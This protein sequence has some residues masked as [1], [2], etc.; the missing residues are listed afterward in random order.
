[1]AN[2]AQ[3]FKINYDTNLKHEVLDSLMLL[4]P[5]LEI[6]SFS[7]LSELHVSTKKINFLCLKDLN[8]LRKLKKTKAAIFIFCENFNRE[9]IISLS[10][11]FNI[12]GIYE[13]KDLLE[14]IHEIKT[15]NFKREYKYGL[16]SIAESNK[17]AQRITKL[18]SL[19]ELLIEIKK[20]FQF[21]KKMNPPMLAIKKSFQQ[22]DLMFSQGDKIITHNIFGSLDDGSRMRKNSTSDREILA[23]ALSRP[24]AK[25][26]A[27]P[28]KVR[29]H[30]ITVFLEHDLSDNELDPQIDV[31][32][33]KLQIIEPIL[34]V[35]LLERMSNEAS[36]IWEKTFES[37]NDPVAIIDENFNLLRGNKR[38]KRHM[39]VEKCYSAFFDTKEVCQYCPIMSK[40][41]ELRGNA[42]NHLITKNGE[43]YEVH[44]SP[45]FLYDKKSV[46]GYANHY[47]NLTE[48]LN[49]KSRII[50]SEKMAAIGHLA[51]NI[52]H[53][54]NNPLTGIRS[55]AQLLIS[56]IHKEC[57][58]KSDLQEVE[59]AAARCQKIILNLLEYTKGQNTGARQMNLNE[60]VGKT[61]PLLKMALRPFR[62]NI[63]YSDEPIE[64][65]INEQLLQQVIFN[66]ILNSTQAMGQK[67]S[68][69]IRVGKIAEE[70]YIQV[71]DDGPGIPH[72]IQNKIF[73][74]FFTTKEKGKGTGLGLSMVKKVVESYGGRLKLKSELG[75]G[76]IMTV[77]I[78]LYKHEDINN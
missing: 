12:L 78:P 29:S 75:K 54:L 51:G 62:V 52:A 5:Q 43:T 7:E 47:I 20:E 14:K 10:Q 34:D 60:V 3:K 18:E 77:E 63:E 2:I 74:P 23:K 68:I 28:I 65:K 37:I 50:Q 24:I 38:F 70:G 35:L 32:S 76:T 36:Q 13:L 46:A 61:I 33:Q 21:I 17:F 40:N 56:E 59:K 19:S 25:V 26:F 4:S 72:E 11:K 27:I 31:I 58:L 9:D 69:N 71:E 16:D 15:F 66:L 49:L 48:T 30:P 73:E 41:E 53:E 6:Q 1:V 45:I 8:N 39:L 57:E 55:I 67:G 64:V 22:V 42:F 44:S